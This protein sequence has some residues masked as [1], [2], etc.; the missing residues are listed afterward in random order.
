M[1][2][3]SLSHRATPPSRSGTV[4]LLIDV[5][6]HMDFPNGHA[7]L[8]NALPAA[9]R[10]AALKERAVQ[11]QI[12]TVYVNDNFGRWQ[13]DFRAQ[14]DHCLQPHAPGREVASLLLPQ[15]DDY[16]VLKPMH[17]GFYSTTLDVLLKHLKARK[18]ILTGF[19]TE[20]CVL[21][22]ANDAYM[23]DFEIIVPADCV[24]SEQSK[25]KIFAL[26]QMK[27]YLKADTRGSRYLRF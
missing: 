7:L 22:T 15:S 27:K 5:I 21:F 14:V 13:S 24:A 6:N 12:P 1:P 3:K 11:K 10:I 20:I 25:D 23:R 19:A 2:V 16:F 9:E 8:R 18:L 26:A 4:L 17:S